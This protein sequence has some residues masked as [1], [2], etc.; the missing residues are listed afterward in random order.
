MTTFTSCFKI[1]SVYTYILV[2]F[3]YW[4]FTFSDICKKD[5]VKIFLMLCHLRNEGIWKLY[6]FI[7]LSRQW[8][9]F[10]TYKSFF[11]ISRTCSFPHDLAFIYALNI[12]EL[13][14]KW[15]SNMNMCATLMWGLKYSWRQS[16][17]KKIR[18]ESRA[19]YLSRM[20]SESTADSNPK[21]WLM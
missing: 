17:R 14:W 3:M 13:K 11:P 20:D 16:L 19:L 4:I 9:P 10:I 8:Y 21:S 12:Q 5:N 18:R 7:D 6:S 2:S 15:N 1:V